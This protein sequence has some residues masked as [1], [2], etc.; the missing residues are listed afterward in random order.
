MSDKVSIQND[1]VNSQRNLATL[2]WQ[3]GVSQS[4]SRLHQSVSQ[5]IFHE[6]EV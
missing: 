5:W 3:K 4:I 6:E 1:N 2:S